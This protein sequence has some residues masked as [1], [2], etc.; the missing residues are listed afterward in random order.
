MRIQLMRGTVDPSTVV[1]KIY[2]FINSKKNLRP[3]LNILISKG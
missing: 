3:F 1:I 2:K